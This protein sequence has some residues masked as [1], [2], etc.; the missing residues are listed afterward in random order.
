ME[1]DD[2][3]LHREVN[4]P[5]FYPRPHMEG[6]CLSQSITSH[7]KQFLPTPSHGGRQIARAVERVPND[8]YPRP[9]M[10][11]DRAPNLQCH[12]RYRISTHALTWR[13]TGGQNNDSDKPRDFYPRPH[14]E[15]DVFGVT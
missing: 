12:S 13:A 3:V 11:G 1:G 8:F 10:E 6:D 5:D 2:V 4:Q 7:G 9:H 15:G 14:M